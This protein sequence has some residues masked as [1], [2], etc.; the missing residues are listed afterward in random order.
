M[1]LGY[2]RWLKKPIRAGTNSDEWCCRA[3]EAPVHPGFSR[4]PPQANGSRGSESSAFTVRS[5]C[6]LASCSPRPKG[7]QR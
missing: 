3:D 2:G 7:N 4:A 5:A 6:N 1:S